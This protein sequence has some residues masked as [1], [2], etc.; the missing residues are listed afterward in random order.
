MTG[1]TRM[2]AGIR[3]DERFYERE[4]IVR[5]VHWGI[6]ELDNKGGSK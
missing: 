2:I 1:E 3:S 5:R 6:D 4:F